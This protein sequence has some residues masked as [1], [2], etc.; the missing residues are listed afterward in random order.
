MLKI[1]HLH[2]YPYSLSGHPS[3]NITSGAIYAKVPI[4]GVC[5]S[6]VLEFLFKILEIPKSAILRT[7]CPLS[8]DLNRIFYGFKSRCIISKFNVIILC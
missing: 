1:S 4:L 6:I 8:F 7:Y 2:E 3:E 5:K